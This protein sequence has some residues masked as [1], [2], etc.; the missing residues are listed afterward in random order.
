[1]NIDKV[2]RPGLELLTASAA[3]DD[4]LQGDPHPAAIR[5]ALFLPSATASCHPVRFAISFDIRRRGGWDRLD[6]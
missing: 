6:R 3:S 2:L 1:M 5:G 4:R